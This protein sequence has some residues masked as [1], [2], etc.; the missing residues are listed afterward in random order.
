M[1]TARH[2]RV[3]E[4]NLTKEDQTH[5]ETHLCVPSW[6][7]PVPAQRTTLPALAVISSKLCALPKEQREKGQLWS[8]QLPKGGHQPCPVPNPD[9]HI[10]NGIAVEK[11]GAV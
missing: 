6:K 11:S 4:P 9:R 8:T 10:C 1:G 2:E 5:W 3:A 7:Q